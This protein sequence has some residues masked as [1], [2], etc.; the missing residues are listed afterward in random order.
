[1]TSALFIRST[2]DAP[3]PSRLNSLIP[4]SLEHGSN[5]NL[6]TAVAQ[7]TH[8]RKRH[9]QLHSAQ[10]HTCM[11]VAS[12]LPARGKRDFANLASPSCCLLRSTSSCK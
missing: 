2:A 9:T 10:P 6:T 4:S 3:Q 5:A 11:V 8:K 12:S 1:M 7:H